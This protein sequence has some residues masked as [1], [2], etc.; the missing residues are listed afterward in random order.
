MIKYGLTI[1]MILLLPAVI[2]QLLMSVLLEIE[3]DWAYFFIMTMFSLVAAIV[4]T[5]VHDMKERTKTEVK[6]DYTASVPSAPMIVLLIILVLN[7][8]IPVRGLENIALVYT[9]RNDDWNGFTSFFKIK[10]IHRRK[11]AYLRNYAL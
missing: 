2:M 1:C 4:L 3:F 5:S 10:V 11:Q 8:S 9:K 6:S 7:T